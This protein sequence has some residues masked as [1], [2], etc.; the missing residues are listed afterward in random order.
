[1]SIFFDKVYFRDILMRDKEFLQELYKNESL[2]NKELIK[3]ADEIRLNTVIQLLHLI[4]NN[5][6]PVFQDDIQ[7]IKQQHLFSYLITNFKS[8]KSLIN[9]LNGS[10]QSKVNILTKFS[11]VYCNLLVNLFEEVR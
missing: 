3:G 5:E 2:P 10:R 1:M 8:Q 7:K 4:T 11:N 6:I 9:I